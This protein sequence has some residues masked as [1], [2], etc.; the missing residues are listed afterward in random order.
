MK[1]NIK[2]ELLELLK[3]ELP[4]NMSEDAKRIK[5]L[6]ELG[7]YRAAYI[8]LEELKCSSK[9]TPTEKYLSLMEDFWWKYAN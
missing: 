4:E 5:T 9:W 8:I 6:I 1:K 2:R 3:Q 7:K